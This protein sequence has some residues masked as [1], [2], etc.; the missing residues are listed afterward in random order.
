MLLFSFFFDFRL[1][2]IEIDM[3][4]RNIKRN[5]F[6]ASPQIFTVPRKNWSIGIVDVI[7][8]ISDSAD[9]C[10][11]GMLSSATAIARNAVRS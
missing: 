1:Y 2:P 11:L 4:K 8:T 9:I 7:S 5:E 10:S 6:K 3:N